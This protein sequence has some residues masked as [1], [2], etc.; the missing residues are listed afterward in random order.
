[1]MRL[2]TLAPKLVEEL[3]QATQGQQR[4]A[5]LAAAEIAIRYMDVED[6]L[7][8][9]LLEKL[10]SDPVFT[11]HERAE[12]DVLIDRL[13]EQYFNLQERVEGNPN[14]ENECLRMFSQARAVSALSFAGMS[15]SFV[16]A[17]EAIYEASMVGDESQHNIIESVESVLNK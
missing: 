16:A 17:M 15:D 8:E 9:K 2:E 14:I 13:D 3:R 1:M 5:G 12:L 6:S 10:K 7:V 11:D 4:A